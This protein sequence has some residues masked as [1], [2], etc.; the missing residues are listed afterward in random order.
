M[1]EPDKELHMRYSH[2]PQRT[3]KKELLRRG[4]LCAGINADLARRLKLDDTFQAKARTAEDYDTMDP[5]EILRLCKCRFIPTKGTDL[6]RRDRLKAH[7][8]RKYGIEAAGSR[9]S[10]L[11]LPRG[12]VSSL[13]KK[14]SQ[15]MREEKRLVPI[16]KNGPNPVTG[17]AE[18][19]RQVAE[20]VTPAMPE[21]DVGLKAIQHPLPHQIIQEEGNERRKSK[22]CWS[23]TNSLGSAD[24]YYSGVVFML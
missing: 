10:P 24:S 17:N 3:M 22:V 14:S 9:M 20:T 15:G 12:P 18:T 2:L 19:I 11:L 4:L 23:P 6:M 7:D 1:M 16:V 8:K 21:D 13:N 5:T